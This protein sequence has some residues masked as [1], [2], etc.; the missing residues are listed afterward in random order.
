M[1][2]EER[3]E[4]FGD[5]LSAALARV[6]DFLKFAEAKN[7]A[8]LTFASAWIFASMNMLNGERPPVGIVGGAFRLAL[9]LFTVAAVVA[10]VSFLPKLNL[11]ALHRDPT[12]PK[13]LLYFGHIAEFDTAVFRTRVQDRYL[14]QEEQSIT[15]QYLDDLAVQISANAKITHWKFIMFNVGAALVLVAVLALA[16]AA[17]SAAINRLSAG[18]LL[19]A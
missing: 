11:A 7:A 4:A 9:V 12:Q 16:L 19:W 5:V 13:N 2:K 1:T 17:V 10:V 15:D 18:V 8:L 14:A 6:V 3:R